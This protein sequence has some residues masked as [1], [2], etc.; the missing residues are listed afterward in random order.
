MTGG[1]LTGRLLIRNAFDVT[2][3]GLE[4]TGGNT[5]AQ[6]G[7]VDVDDGGRITL[8]NLNVHNAPGACVSMAR[9]A[10][11]LVQDSLLSACGQE[12]YHGDGGS[13]ITYRGNEIR[14][15]NTS[16]APPCTDSRS[17]CVNGRW[18][19]GWEAGGGKQTK[20]QTALYENNISYG[21]GGPGLWCDIDCKNVTY[22]F[23]R[24]YDNTQ[25][26]FFEISD[27][28]EIHDNVT[29]RNGGTTPEWCYRAGIIVSSSKNANVHDNVSA[30]DNRG[31]TFLSQNRGGAWNDTSGNRAANNTVISSTGRR[32]MNWCQDWSGNLF[33]TGNNGAGGRYWAA[34]SEPQFERFEWA[35]PLDTV[36]KF[37]NSPGDEGGRYL[38]TAEKDSILAAKGLPATP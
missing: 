13:N 17:E 22:R 10:T 19:S 8:K 11:A 15:N 3:D 9:V 27:G 29:Y 25:G 14:W 30:W 37:N 18:Q 31:I 23:N 4:V 7:A 24:A 21:N 6:Q 26:I 28:A 38:T 20:V 1:K 16:L 32:M 12:G 36:A 35:T 33:T 5:P 2:V 34:Q